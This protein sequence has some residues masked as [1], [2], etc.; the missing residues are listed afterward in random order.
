[1][2][3]ELKDLENM[4]VNSLMNLVVNARLAIAPELHSNSGEIQRNY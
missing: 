3:L 4:R 1:M 2:L